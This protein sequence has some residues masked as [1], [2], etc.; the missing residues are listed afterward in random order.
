MNV[1]TEH[2]DY[3]KPVTEYD[4]EDNI[5]ISRDEIGVGADS[6][7]RTGA[8]D[9]VKTELSSVMAA[10]AALVGRLTRDDPGN[11]VL[12]TLTHSYPQADANVPGGLVVKERHITGISVGE[13][14]VG[15]GSTAVQYRGYLLNGENVHSYEYVERGGSIYG[16]HCSGVIPS[17]PE[18]WDD[19]RVAT[20]EEVLKQVGPLL[21]DA[22]DRYSIAA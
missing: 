18:G 10:A 3:S 4:N 16:A 12:R 6:H 5:Q 11:P 2:A 15:L 21:G 8:L 20:A 13:Y 19:T 22:I 7:E 14:A 9:V 17:T 1:M